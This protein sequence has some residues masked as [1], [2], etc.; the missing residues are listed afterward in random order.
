MPHSL[1]FN[2]IVQEEKLGWNNTSIAVAANLSHH[3][4]PQLRKKNHQANA[5]S[6]RPSAYARAIDA[7]TATP[8]WQG[9]GVKI[10]K[11]IPQPSPRR[12]PCSCHHTKATEFPPP[13]LPPSPQANYHTQSPHTTTPLT[14]VGEW[15]KAQRR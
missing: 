12:Q 15:A 5:A 7:A 9:G 2:A 3:T 8:P 4:T 14:S 1:T 10:D 13:P 11:I 6:P